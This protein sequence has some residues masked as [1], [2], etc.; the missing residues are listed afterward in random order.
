[1]NAEEFARQYFAEAMGVDLESKPVAYESLTEFAPV[2]YPQFER[3]AHQD[4]LDEHLEQVTRYV[5]TRGAEGIG[6]LIIEMPPRH[7][8]TWKTSVIYPIWH[9]GR[10]PDH[11]IMM[12]SYAQSLADVNSRMARDLTKEPQYF[13]T[14]GLELAHDNQSVRSWNLEGR[15]GGCHALG[16]GAGAAGKGAHVLIIDDPH[17]GRKE[18][19]SIV[20][21][22]SVYDAYVND[23]K[24]RLAPGGAVIIMATRWH[25]DDLTGRVL[26]DDREDGDFVR[27]RLPALAEE[28]DPLGRAVGEALWEAWF[29]RSELLKHK[30]HEYTWLS[31]YQQRPIAAEGNIFKENWFTA[32]RVVPEIVRTVRFW[33]LAMSESTTADYTVGLKLGLGRNGEHYVLDVFR[34][35]IELFDLPKRIKDVMLDDGVDVVQGFEKAGYM[36]RAIQQVA[37]DRDLHEFVME[38]FTPDRDKLTRALPVASRC[39]LKLIHLKT[40]DWNRDFVDELKAFNNGTH[41]DQVDAFSG[42]W[43]LINKPQRK[44]L[45]TEVKQ[46]A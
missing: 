41:D 28:D 30:K 4:L 35:R 37:K 10:N 27:L 20:S 21:R 34:D 16:I 12:V 13:E 46:Y 11:R 24:T 22:D 5:E 29:P 42:A 6:R 14:F 36:T 9:L 43:T 23:L 40:A 38:T 17:K 2:I 45:T 33:D 8:K 31:L 25:E 32:F 1:M 44:K 39:A 18:V 19:E 26:R 3:A 7:G 15:T